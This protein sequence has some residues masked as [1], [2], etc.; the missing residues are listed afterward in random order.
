MGTS[1]RLHLRDRDRRGSKR[2]E[3]V[4]KTISKT[5][6]NIDIGNSERDKRGVVLTLVLRRAY[7]SEGCCNIDLAPY[8]SAID[9]PYHLI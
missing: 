7:E 1:N 9:P 3:S 5:S 8:L 2:R 4:E 6:R